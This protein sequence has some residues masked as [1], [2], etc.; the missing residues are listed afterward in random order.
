MTMLG[1]GFRRK[2]TRG[3]AD[4]IIALALFWTAALI[5]GVN[6]DDRAF[7]VPLPELATDQ[8]LRELAGPDPVSFHARGTT[9]LYTPQEEPAHRLQTIMLLSLAFAGLAAF[10]LAF[11]RHLRRAY[12][13]PR[14]G[15][16]R[17]G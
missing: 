12:A 16:W 6:L 1:S 7:A 13:S 15:V 8:A 5:T 2:L 17:G 4:F 10:N 11:W 9:S 14:R 3:L